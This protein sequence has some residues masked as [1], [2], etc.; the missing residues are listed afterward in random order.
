MRKISILAV[1]IAFSAEIVADQIIGFIMVL[2]LG[3]GALNSGMTEQEVTAALKTVAESPAFLAGTMAFGTATT[4]AGA[5]LAAR[6]A[7]SFPYYNG[8]A[9]GLVGL[10]LQL[11][12][13]RLNPLWMN[14]T[15]VITVIPMSLWGA[16]LAKPHLPPPE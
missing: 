12:F 1:V 6:I 3:Q 14:I 5:Y 15:S 2:V 9:M 10:A 7:R 13:W 11:Y 16:H 8:L 4:V